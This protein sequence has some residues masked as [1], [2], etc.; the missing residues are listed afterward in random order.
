MPTGPDGS[1]PCNLFGDDLVS[2][3]WTHLEWSWLVQMTRDGVRMITQDGDFDPTQMVMW[4][5]PDH[6]RLVTVKPYGQRLAYELHAAISGSPVKPEVPWVPDRPSCSWHVDVYRE[7]LRLPPGQVTDLFAVVC[8]HR[9]P[10]TK[11]TILQAVRECPLAPLVPLHRVA[12][13]QQQRI[14]FP[15]GRWWRDYLLEQERQA[16][17][18]GGKP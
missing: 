15:W 11:K 3:R 17:R 7:L 14:R 12:S 8:Y 4:P 1:I 16:Y 10:H 6:P 13:S 18:Q 5:D 2:A 9:W